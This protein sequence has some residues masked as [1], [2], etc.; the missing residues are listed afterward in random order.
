MVEAKGNPNVHLTVN[1]KQVVLQAG[2]KKT[3]KT[4]EYGESD[5]TTG[6]D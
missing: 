3:I 6:I 4:R 2:K 5:L 1:G